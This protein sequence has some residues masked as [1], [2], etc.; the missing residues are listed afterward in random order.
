MKGFK[1]VG[2]GID[3]GKKSVLKVVIK[4]KLIIYNMHIYWKSEDE[5]IVDVGRV[6]KEDAGGVAF[7]ICGD[8]NKELNELEDFMREAGVRGKVGDGV[9]GVHTRTGEMAMIDHVLVSGGVKMG[10]TSIIENVNGC[11]IMYNKKRILE[12]KWGCNDISDHLP[13]KFLINGHLPN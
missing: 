6:V 10:T 2:C 13:V 5:E 1:G 11:E 9:T 7:I 4:D 8:L 12:G 3:A